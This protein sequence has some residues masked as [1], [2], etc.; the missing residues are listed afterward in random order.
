MDVAETRLRQVLEGSKQYRVPLYQRPYSWQRKQLDRLWSDIVEL[1]EARKT[2]PAATHFTGSLVLSLGQVGPGGSEFLVVDGQQRL[3]TLSILLCAIRDHLDPTVPEDEL[4]RQQI[5]E[6]FI[7]DRFKSGDE[8]LKVLPTQAD[9]DVYRGI[10]DS[11]G[12][13]DAASGVGAAYRFFERQLEVADDPD[14]PHDIRRIAEAT[15]DALAFVSITA[16][17][18]DNVYRIFESLNNTGM[19][20]TQGDLLR[21]YIFMRMGNDGDDVYSSWWLPMQNRLS[22]SDLEALFWMDMVATVADVKQGDIYAAQESRLSKLSDSEVFDEVKRFSRL[23]QLLELMRDPSKEEDEATR[24]SLVRIQNWKAA[25]A[26]PLILYLLDRRDAGSSTTEEVASALAIL[27]SF[28]VRRLVGGAPGSGLSRILLR[29]P[30]DSQP[31]IPV[32]TALIAYLSSGRKFFATDEQI[33][34]A[35]KTKP[36]YFT[37]SPAQ[38]ALLLEW[39]EETYGSK[40]PIDFAK[41]S[42]EH[43]MPQKLTVAWR[44]MISA[45]VDEGESVDVI[46]D[47]LVHTLGNLTLTAYNSELS[48]NS[49]EQKKVELARSGIRMNAEIAREP[50]WGRTEILKRAEV[51]AEKICATWIAPVSSDEAVDTG[52][53]WGLVRDLVSAVP[54]GKWTT[55]GD[56]AALAGTHALPLG[57]F[58]AQNQIPGAWRV[59]QAGGTVSP[60]FRWEQG[61]QNFGRSPHEVLQA[62]GLSFDQAN[63]ADPA[64]QVTLAFLA[65]AVGIELVDD[66]TEGS[67]NVNDVQETAFI[68]QLT[69]SQPPSVVHGVIELLRQWESLGGVVEFG[70][71]EETS[72]FFMAGFTSISGRKLWPIVIYP[73]LG[74]VEVIFQ[75]LAARPPFDD[76]QLREDMR[77]RLNAIR[78]VE[79]PANKLEARPSFS[80]DLLADRK[81]RSEV[82]D[83]LEWFLREA[84][85]AAQ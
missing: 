85:A 47:E 29:A 80:V 7:V 52:V 68:S 12:E 31:D 20:L 25:P 24:R 16:R 38:K 18:D 11:T 3:T 27:E 73:R 59:L 42:I 49:F 83:V 62:E 6:S 48:N 37:G 10:V 46:H 51:L 66:L 19:K 71:A 8:R 4:W 72:C 1:A 55:Y 67:T 69:E 56:V 43:V 54:E 23:S 65:Q 32:D 57:Q 45:E 84:A 22:S 77:T 53:S 39:L 30:S 75:H 70:Q 28:F 63:R 33:R 40:E 41:A 13:V 35:V 2:E 44:D 61:S 81:V 50:R 15:L 78:G 82:A 26:D 76:P 34:S 9:R 74:T 79:L 64:Q 14:D 17:N 58:L 36:F 60:G 21:N 5:H